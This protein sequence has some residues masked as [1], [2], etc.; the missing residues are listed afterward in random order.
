MLRQLDAKVR[1]RNSVFDEQEAN[2][3]CYFQVMW[4]FVVLVFLLLCCN[5]RE[6]SCRC[7][8]VLV[9]LMIDNSCDIFS[10]CCQCMLLC[11]IVTGH[12]SRD[13]QL[14]GVYWSTRYVHER[15]GMTV[16]KFYT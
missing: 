4:V 12:G 3:K 10:H 11:L 1:F 9:L 8:L 5:L 7:V 6:N 15:E 16:T 13:S 14:A 2:N